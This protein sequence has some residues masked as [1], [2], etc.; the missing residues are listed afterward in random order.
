MA[1]P[2][3]LHML[4]LYSPN[5]YTITTSSDRIYNKHTSHMQLSESLY[6]RTYP[7]GMQLIALFALQVHINSQTN[8]R[9]QSTARL[10][11][12]EN[13]TSRTQTGKHP[14]QASTDSQ[15]ATEIKTGGSFDHVANKQLRRWTEQLA[16]H[17]THCS[18][19]QH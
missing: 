3:C 18:D 17:R 7:A 13:R 9:P 4:C 14:D 8:D 5:P 10:M 2:S 11:H 16:I 12:N 15:Q 19:T 6:I 1:P